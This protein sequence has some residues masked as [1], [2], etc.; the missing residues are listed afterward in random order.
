ME[1]KPTTSHLHLK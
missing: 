1:P